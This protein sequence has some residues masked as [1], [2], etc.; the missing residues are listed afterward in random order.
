MIGE[1]AALL[2]DLSEEHRALDL[3]VADI[4]RDRWE[5]STPCEGWRVRDQ[6]AHLAFFDEGATL[7][8][9]DRSRFDE[10]ARAAL[11]DLATYEARYIERGRRLTPNALLRWWRDARERLVAAL[12]ALDDRGRMPW[13]GVTMSPASFTTARLM[14]TWSHGQD[15][16]DALGVTRTNTDRLRHVAFLGARTRANAYV[17]H[18]MTPPVEPVRIELVLPSG[19]AWIDGDATAA[20][21]VVGLAVDFC[22][23]VTQ[24][25]HVADTDLRVDGPI[26]EQWMGIAQAF[27]G[28]PGPGRRPGQFR[29]TVGSTGTDATPT[30]GA[31]RTA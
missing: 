27:A 5:R 23:V 22:L 19:G 31:W 6:I 3:I 21:R 29:T 26:A 25:R 30:P 24:R 1:I 11:A 12:A 17:A 18:G 4:D 8:A 2:A 20:N 13:Y 15:V 14:E 9:M 28:P 16:A 7:A 10:E